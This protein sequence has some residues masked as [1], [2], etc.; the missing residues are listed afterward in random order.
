MKLPSPIWGSLSKEIKTSSDSAFRTMLKPHDT[1]SMKSSASCP[2]GF[3]S[4]G[5]TPHEMN[6]LKPS[7]H[8]PWG[9]ISSVTTPIFSK[10]VTIEEGKNYLQLIQ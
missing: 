7:T 4:N 3:T 6:I 10:P 1:N 2:T 8:P 5:K 9:S